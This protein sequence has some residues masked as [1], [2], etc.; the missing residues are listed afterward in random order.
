MADRW[1]RRLRGVGLVVAGWAVLG[2]AVYGGRVYLKSA[3]PAYSYRYRLVVEVE[4]DN[5]VHAGSSVI[6]VEV[7]TQPRIL[8]NS[9][10]AV[11]RH[12]DGVFVDLGGGQHVI[13]LLAA[14]GKAQDVDYPDSLVPRL[15][16]I[17][18]GPEDLP[19]LATL[20]GRRALPERQ[21]PTFVTF[22][23]LNEAASVRVVQPNDFANAFRPGVH[24]KSV[25]LEMTDD[26]VTRQIEARM[27]RVIEQLRE[28]AKAPHVIYNA[29]PYVAE[30]GHFTIK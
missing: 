13:A 20:R 16:P 27:P 8:N 26:P 30:L 21:F 19:K 14:G 7:R 17:S 10:I 6:E 9:T 11:R 4:A 29:D 5:V 15:F 18:Y 1:A 23:D 24:I 3:Y 25:W 2:A 28:R 22:A 12:G